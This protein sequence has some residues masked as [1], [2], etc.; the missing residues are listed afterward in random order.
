MARFAADCRGKMN[1]L[2]TKLEVNLGA[3]T[4]DLSLRIGLNS[5][6]V[7]AGILRGQKARFQLFGD[8]VNTAARME[9]NGVPNK[10]HVSEATAMELI[11]LNKQAWLTKREDMITAKGKGQMVT[12][13]V[14]PQR[15]AGSAI[16][17][18]TLGASMSFGRDDDDVNKTSN[19]VACSNAFGTSVPSDS[20]HTT[21]TVVE[22]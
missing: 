21:A 12:Y 15:M 16:T 9:S 7:T 13:W 22:C 5:G 1:E 3:A 11:S 19:D 6:P 8:T 14:E 20:D 17:A 10:I 2:V 4:A 18:E